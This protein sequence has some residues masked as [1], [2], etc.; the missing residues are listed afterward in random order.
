MYNTDKMNVL[1]MW[2]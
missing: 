1:A 2:T